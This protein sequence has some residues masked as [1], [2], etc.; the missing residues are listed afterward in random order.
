MLYINN[1]GMNSYV[2]YAMSCSHLYTNTIY[3][4]IPAVICTSCS[5]CEG[6][7]VEERAVRGA[8][9]THGMIDIMA[10][11]IRMHW[12]QWAACDDYNYI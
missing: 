12:N 5:Q 9:E 6:G 3:Y 8:N 7:A 10:H 1:I 4:S 11:W 2:Y